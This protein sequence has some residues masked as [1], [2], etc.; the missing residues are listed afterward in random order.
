MMAN[1]ELTEKS[2]TIADLKRLI[3]NQ[4]SIFVRETDNYSSSPARSLIVSTPLFASSVIR[5]FAS[6][7]IKFSRQSLSR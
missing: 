2:I 1:G 6:T 3:R 5:V 7:G 4:W